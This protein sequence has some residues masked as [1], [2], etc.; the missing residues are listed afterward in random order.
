MTN[1]RGVFCRNVPP[2][3]ARLGDLKLFSVDDDEHAQ[4]LQIVD[5]VKHPSYTG[6]LKYNDV[7]LFKLNKPVVVDEFVVPAC[8]WLEKEIPFSEVEVAGWGAT[9][10]CEDNFIANHSVTLI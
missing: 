8:L 2:D 4:Q 1:N 10:E 7:V 3:V 9:G 5:I 6:R